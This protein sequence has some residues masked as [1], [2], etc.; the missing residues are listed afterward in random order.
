MGGQL[1]L[2]MG[3]L[4][5]EAVGAPTVT[6]QRGTAMLEREYRYYQDHKAELDSKYES[7]FIVIVGETVLGDFDSPAVAAEA[8]KSQHHS[9]G[10]FLVQFCS[11]KQDQT[12]HFHSRAA[13]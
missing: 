8:A 9:P 3:T 10:K 5:I 4:M 1:Q 7:R 12:Q 13:F 6:L 11:S 2:T